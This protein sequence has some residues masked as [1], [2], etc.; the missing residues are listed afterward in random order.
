[1]IPAPAIAQADEGGDAPSFVLA[2]G[3]GPMLEGRGGAPLSR[4]GALLSVEAGVVLP[5]GSMF[6][7]ELG[8]RGLSRAEAPVPAPLSRVAHEVSALFGIRVNLRDTPGWLGLTPIVRGGLRVGATRDEHH[9]LPGA[10]LGL[11]PLPAT[12]DRAVLGPH[13]G[14]LVE[15]RLLPGARIGLGVTGYLA[16]APVHLLTLVTLSLSV[17]SGG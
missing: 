11:A 15:R 1:M 4:T 7:F 16:I 14:L 5:A 17:G 6:A 2:A 8:V 13:L 3:V 9:P 12:E 10:H